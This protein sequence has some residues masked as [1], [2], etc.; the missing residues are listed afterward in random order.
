[1]GGKAGTTTGLA[2]LLAA[3]M[4]GASGAPSGEGNRGLSPIILSPIISSDFSL[5]AEGVDMV[6]LAVPDTAPLPVMDAT[7]VVA[8]AVSPAEIA[9][10][11]VRRMTYGVCQF[12]PQNDTPM[13]AAQEFSAYMLTPRRYMNYSLSQRI[14]DNLAVN[15]LLQSDIDWYDQWFGSLK[16][17]VLTPPSHGKFVNVATDLSY[18]YLPNRGYTGQDRVDLLVEGKDDLGQ[19]V[20]MTLRYYVNILPQ[21]EFD[22]AIANSK[23]FAKATS[24][25][26]GSS[27]D[28][29]RIST[30]FTIPAL[31]NAALQ[32]LL[33]ATDIN[34]SVTVNTADLPG[35]SLGQTTNTTITLDTDAAG[36]G[37]YIDYTP[38]L[39]EDY[40]PTSNPYE[41]IA[42]EGT[43][44]YGKMDLLSVL[45]HEYG[46]ALG[47][48]HS[49]DSHDLMAATLS[50]GV[51][52]L[53]DAETLAEF[54]RMLG[55][56]LAGDNLPTTPDIPHPD[57]P[58][59]PN[60]GR[61]SNI[62]VA[63]VRITRDGTFV[64]GEDGVEREQTEYQAAANPTL[65]DQR[66]ETGT[67]WEVTGNVAIGN[68]AAIL[69]ESPTNQTRL[70]QVFL[71]GEHDRYLTFTLA[72][73]ALDD[74]NN[75]P[76][77]AFEAALLDANSGLSLLG[78]TGLTRNDA[79][80]NLQANGTERAGQGV[81]STLNA[82]GSRTYR[83]DLAGIPAG[84]AVNLS[85]DLIGFGA[86]TSQV[87]VRDIRLGVPETRDDT[88][89][90]AEDTPIDIAVTANDLDADQ[91]GFTPVIVAGPEHGT[92]VLN[93]AGGFTYTPEADWNG[94]DSFT[95]KLSDG[96]VDSN[97]AKVSLGVTA[98]NDAPTAGDQTLAT[99][100]DAALTLDLLAQAA[101]IDSPTLTP[102]IVS[103]PQHG[104]L[105]RNADGGFTYTPDANWNG[106]DSFTYRV[107][108]GEL[109][110]AIATV[111]IA[112][113]A[114]NDAPTI[115]PRTLT[116]DEDV[117][118]I[119][120]LLEGAED[121]D[122]DA[123]E[124]V[125][126]SG[127]QHGALTQSADGTWT[128]T[129]DENFNG[130]D[131]IEYKV[132]DGETAVETFSR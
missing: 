51:R 108:D 19:A 129:P 90:T 66:L 88:A 11:S 125:I 22:E 9:A 12:V 10:P 3:G 47:L 23:N 25:Y 8:A 76:D 55:Y 78:G 30:T 100:E 94:E 123:L 73:I 45:W 112:V 131:R 65:T 31:D 80:L 99:L 60:N 120:D 24:K 21:K 106:E 85:F 68:G 116:L 111:R 37:W 130:E 40:L 79:F 62:R 72:G 124:A 35:S 48:S 93:A 4:A 61:N 29:W 2:L 59:S 43:D 69:S 34:N 6:F 118:L 54:R 109:D 13:D 98:V 16:V 103:G 107:N 28:A 97:I 119:L 7:V 127:P 63:R 26:C 113:A 110:S 67:G 86:A 5:N 15:A 50:P 102:T 81:T 56:S 58:L 122:G 101:D 14:Q 17:S 87:T 75:A 71:V 52:R 36:H 117:P 115:A 92:V 91:P 74:V 41:W 126:S 77:D 82:D 38:Y 105:I 132:G 64:I 20:S 32:A 18:Q 57:G 70:N 33:D 96:T 27:K 95:Y 44:A 83:I 46:H 104:T 49:A 1:M 42:K 84:T 89:T 128:Y 39:N 53:P 121:V 114:V